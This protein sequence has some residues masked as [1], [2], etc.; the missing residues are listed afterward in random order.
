MQ[1]P[2]DTLGEC[3]HLTHLAT[4]YLL[5]L[6]KYGPITLLRILAP[7]I[8]KTFL[9]LKTINKNTKNTESK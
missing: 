8:R 9:M 4:S 3:G 1:K 7:L 5:G 6:R 2:Y